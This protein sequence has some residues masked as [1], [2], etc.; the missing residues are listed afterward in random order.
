V[1][2]S[3]HVECSPSDIPIA[4]P[5]RLARGVSHARLVFSNMLAFIRE[6]NILFLDAK[7]VCN[8]LFCMPYRINPVVLVSVMIPCLDA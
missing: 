7:K 1:Q 3:D 4:P 8:V 2:T 6:M 5:A